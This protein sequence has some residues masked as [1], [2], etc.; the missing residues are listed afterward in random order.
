MNE[1]GSI[2]AERE[3]FILGTLKEKGPL[4]VLEITL[5]QETTETNQASLLHAAQI[6]ASCMDL[7][8]AG[9]IRKVPQTLKLEIIEK[10]E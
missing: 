9:Y 2:A 1:L 7:W 5:L 3:Q 8:I 6:H 4:T 10:N